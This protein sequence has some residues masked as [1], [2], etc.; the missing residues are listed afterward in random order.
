MRGQLASS[1]RGRWNSAGTSGREQKYWGAVPK[2]HKGG[3]K[4]RGGAGTLLCPLTALSSSPICVGLPGAFL[5]GG[6]EGQLSKCMGVGKG[7][8][9]G[10]SFPL[11][12]PQLI[13]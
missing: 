2:G 8:G 1:V 10:E 6:L 3:G 4:A 13:T 9:G 5:S 7:G 12:Q 11:G